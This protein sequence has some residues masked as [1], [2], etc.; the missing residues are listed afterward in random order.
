MQPKEKITLAITT[1]ERH[2]L[3]LKAF[4]NVLGDERLEQILLLDDN[5]KDGSFERLAERFENSIQVKVVQQILNR[6]MQINKSDAVKLSPSNWVILFDSDNVISKKYIDKIYELPVWNNDTIYAPSRA[7]PT[8]LYDEFAG[9]E[10][11]RRNVKEFLGKSFFGAAINTCNY[12]LN[13]DFYTSVFKY[14]PLVKETDTANHFYNHL[15]ADGKFYVVPGLEYSHL[16]HENSGF[17]Q[18]ASYNMASAMD[19][20]KQL[21]QL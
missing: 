11:S 13:K 2:D 14:N 21:M 4:Q 6:Q 12:F 18:N 19:I 20:E 1:F 10:I 9:V 5:S 8:F 15:K 16:V 7:L 3:T 17:M